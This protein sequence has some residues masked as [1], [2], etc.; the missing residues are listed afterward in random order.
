MANE[1][2]FLPEFNKVNSGTDTRSQGDDVSRPD[3]HL[4][5]PFGDIPCPAASTPSDRWWFNSRRRSHKRVQIK[6]VI[7][8]RK[9]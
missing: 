2:T 5:F 6:R 1:K 7:Q 8:R 3:Q 4:Y 9:R